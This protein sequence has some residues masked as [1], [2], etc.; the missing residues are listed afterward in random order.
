MNGKEQLEHA[1]ERVIETIAMNMNLYGVTDSVGRLYGML[2]FHDQPLTLDEMKE[3][4]GM[5][6]TS[7]STSVRTLLELKMV[8][9]IWKKGI[10][11]DLYQA[12]ED[13]YQTFTDFFTIKWRAGISMNVSAM[14]KSLRELEI[15]VNSEETDE[16]IRSAARIDM[17]KM[18]DALRYYTWLNRL[19]DSFDSGKIFD[20]IPKEEEK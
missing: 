8:E 16:E 11:K 1:R 10:R 20:Y 19:V 7:M 6:K 13:W 14:K 2:Y 3:E 18:N 15:L 4:L 9:K 17:E 5:S 12:E